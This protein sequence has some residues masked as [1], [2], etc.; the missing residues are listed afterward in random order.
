MKRLMIAGTLGGLVL[1]AALTVATASSNDAS[2]QTTE[3]STVEELVEAVLDRL[4]ASGIIT[5]E[6]AEELADRI[7]SSEPYQR[8]VD[9]G[10]PEQ[11]D[12]GRLEER[13]DKG[14]DRLA[15]A[16][17]KYGELDRDQ[18]RE[19][20]AE[21]RE[22]H[23]DAVREFR[24]RRRGLGNSEL[25]EQLSEFDRDEIR[26]AIE[27]GTLDELIDT[28]A[29]ADS[30]LKRAEEALDRAVENGRITRDEADEKLAE[31]AE[32]LEQLRNGDI[33]WSESFTRR[34]RDGKRGAEESGPG[35]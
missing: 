12:D 4:V 20:F 26:D 32:R 23:R 21:L 10:L 31:L 22:R 18:L 29:F 33:D 15:E 16:K 5:E 19:G 25:R 2:A 17:R 24:E 8:W 11:F 30:M 1:A 7:Y 34:W 27:N 28:E 3:A 9:N 13:L 6:R 35:A 14:L